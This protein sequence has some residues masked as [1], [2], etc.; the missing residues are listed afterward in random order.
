MHPEHGNEQN[1]NDND[2][3]PAALHNTNLNASR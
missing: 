2:E 1:N 3:R